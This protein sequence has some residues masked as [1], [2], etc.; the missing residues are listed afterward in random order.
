MLHHGGGLSLVMPG[1]PRSSQLRSSGDGRTV[2]LRSPPVPRP[3]PAWS[4][5]R[6]TRYPC[7]WLPPVE[8]RSAAAVF[9][10]RLSDRQWSAI[11]PTC[12]PPLRDATTGPV[13]ISP[14]AAAGTCRGLPSGV[15]C[16]RRLHDWP[17]T[18]SR[19]WA[20]FLG[21]GP[22]AAAG[23]NWP[24]TAPTS[25]QK[26]GRRVGRAAT[27]T[28]VML[29][30]DLHAERPSAETRGR[31]RSVMNYGP[32]ESRGAGPVRC[33]TGCTT[34]T[35]G[36]T[37]C[38][39]LRPGVPAPAT[40]SA[41]GPARP[42][43]RRHRRR[44]AVERTFAGK[45][46]RRLCVSHERRPDVPAPVQLRPD[47]PRPVLKPSCSHRRAQRGGVGRGE[48]GERQAAAGEGSEP[49]AMLTRLRSGRVRSLR[50]GVRACHPLPAPGP[51]RRPVPRSG[52]VLHRQPVAEG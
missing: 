3:S 10:P 36:G 45:A 22:G 19:L 24:W 50:F 16:W 9:R 46:E 8:P 48:H 37:P 12:M 17:P 40:E 20:S 6:R 52:R 39:R 51:S 23:P 47:P 34:A 28:R 4:M 1:T 27:G 14:Q 7:G 25:R 42:K 44:W 35:T 38:L 11:A 33:R 49:P 26:R 15:T 32:A 30:A 21:R 31:S 5:S 43:L 18:D 2:A 29:V 13:S 41:A